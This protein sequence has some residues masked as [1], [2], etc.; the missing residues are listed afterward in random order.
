MYAGKRVLVTGGLGFIGSNLAI[1]LVELG[2]LVAIVDASVPGC[3]ANEFNIEPVKDR[4][5]VIPLDIADA[6]WFQDRIRCSDVIFNIAGEISHAESMRCPERDLQINTQAQ[7]RFLLACRAARPGVRVVFAGTRQVYGRA[8][9]LPV[10][11]ECRPD[12]VDFNGIHKLAATH[13]HVVLS[14]MGDI[15]AVVLRL[16]NVY[17]PRMA[18]N[19]PHQGFLGTFLRLA[20]TGDRLTVYG[21]GSSLRDPVYVDDAV[22]AFLIAGARDTHKS[23]IYNVGGPEALSL[24]D[25]A[26]AITA[27]AG[28]PPVIQAPFP[29]LQKAIDIGSYFSNSQLI[30]R[31]LGWRPRTRFRDG[32]ERTLAYYRKHLNSY[33]GQPDTHPDLGAVALAKRAAEL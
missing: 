15:D 25:L 16:T 11:E 30:R 18:L 3:G 31:E 9:G 23:A 26:E 10:D 32:V 2:A 29:V 28:L 33:L 19:L 24:S 21:D 8:R 4:L 12:P 13:Y 27:A 5:E 20:S 22:E 14:R 17:G 1:R 7:L 6:A